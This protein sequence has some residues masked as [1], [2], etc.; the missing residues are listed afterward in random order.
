[1]DPSAGGTEAVPTCAGGRNVICFLKE[2]SQS[3]ISRKGKKDEN[4]QEHPDRVYL[5]HD[6][7]QLS[8]S[9]ISV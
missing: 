9:D 5:Y 2:A 4:T 1:M 7:W 8:L 6:P 3:A